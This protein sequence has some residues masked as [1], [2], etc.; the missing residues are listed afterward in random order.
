[1]RILL[2]TQAVFWLWIGSSRLGLDARRLADTALRADSLVVSAV[3]FC[4]V[5]L[6]TKENRLDVRMSAS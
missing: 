4:E 3:T 2:D 6:P 1:M 5:G